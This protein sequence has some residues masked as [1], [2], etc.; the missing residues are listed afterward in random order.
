[1][2]NASHVISGH[3]PCGNNY[4]K[5]LQKMSAVASK[6]QHL[7]ASAIKSITYEEK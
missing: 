6:E 3:V 7:L 5:A 2:K 1:M 4:E